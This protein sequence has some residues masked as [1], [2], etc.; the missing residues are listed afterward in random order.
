MIQGEKVRLRGFDETDIGLLQRWAND[1][2]VSRWMINRYPTALPDERE[3]VQDMM[4][5][6]PN[7]KAFAIESHDG[8]L[9]GWCGL[10]QI[11]WEDRRASLA[12][13]IGDKTRWGHGYG[14][15]ATRTLVRFG[16]EEMNLNRIDLNVHA[17]NARAV[18]CYEKI[19]FIH[20]GVLRGNVYR[21]GEC[22]DSIVMSVLRH[23]SLDASSARHGKD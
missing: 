19:G 14:T 2:D 18:R 20:E 22:V 12:I 6:Q 11:S 21:D 9:I 1:W 8:V 16:F 10:C 17:D 7:E 23:E 13:A 15:D 4:K 5:P 3:G